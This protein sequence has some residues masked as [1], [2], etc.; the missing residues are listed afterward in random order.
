GR[1][2]ARG[3]SQALPR[4]GPRR[5]GRHAEPAALRPGR[6][7]GALRRVRRALPAHVGPVRRRGPLPRRR[8][9]RAGGRA[10]PV[11]GRGA[12]GALPQPAGVQRHGAR[13]GV[14]GGDLAAHARPRGGRPAGH[15]PLG[16]R[17]G[18]CSPV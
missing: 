7:T 10:R 11:L 2:P 4:R 16:Q 17:P 3:R 12:P 1:R 6:R 18:R 5:S 9:H 8:E 13:P 14:R 15:R